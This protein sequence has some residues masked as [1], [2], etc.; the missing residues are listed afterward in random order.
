MQTTNKSIEKLLAVGKSVRY[1]GLGAGQVVRHDR[2]EVAGVE[3]VFAVIFMPHRDLSMQVPLTD[4]KLVDKVAPIES[5][6]A[7]RA[8]L[9]VIGQKGKTLHRTWDERER[10]GR[11]RLNTGGPQEWAELLRD[12]ATAR[13]E[14]LPIAASDADI[15]RDAIDLLAAE[16]ACAT[17][18][19]FEKATS[20]I[21]TAYEAAHGG[22]KVM[23]R[24]RRRKAALATTTA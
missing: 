4:P 19:S 12:Y 5:A 8:L 20:T 22:A 3:R 15:V 24:R 18:W 14:G 7:L 16:L 10:A 6:T 11:R 13:R 1:R 2:R 23:T 9:P 17:R 21:D